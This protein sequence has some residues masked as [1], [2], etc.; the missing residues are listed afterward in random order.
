MRLQEFILESKN[1]KMHTE[2][3]M[4]SDF[5]EYKHKE[6]KKWKSRAQNNGF[7]FPIFDDYSNFKQSLKSGKVMALTDTMKN[8]IPGSS[9]FNNIED[10][11]NMVSNYPRPRDIKRIIDGFEKGQK[12]PYP[13]ILK[14]SKG[15][16][17]Y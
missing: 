8:K 14:G 10:L 3:D 1:W 17:K 12:L 6:F 16:F 4:K 9:S 2:A 15:W 13:I 11:T 5:A 7:R